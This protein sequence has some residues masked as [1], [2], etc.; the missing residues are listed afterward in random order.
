MFKQISVSL[1]N[2]PGELYGISDMLRD[3]GVTI[4][5]IA[6]DTEAD[7][8]EVRLVVD[9]PQKAQAVCESRGYTV[10]VRPVLAVAVPDHPG[11]FNSVFKPLKDEAVNVLYV[12]PFM[13]RFRE[14]TVLAIGVDQTE[15]AIEVL[16]RNYIL[17]LSKESYSV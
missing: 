5:A 11:G 3:E 9:D 14:E 16:G 10:T 17:V 6:S 2:R 4:L 13:G 1:D 8:S 12:Y 15:K 7:T